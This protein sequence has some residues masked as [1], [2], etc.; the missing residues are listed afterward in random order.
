MSTATAWPT[1]VEGTGPPT[2]KP[3]PPGFVIRLAPDVRV[4]PRP[5]GGVLLGGSPLRVLR[6]NAAAWREFSALS[7]G[8]A[9]RSRAAGRVAARLVDAGIAEPVPPAA[10]GPG[11]EEVTIVIP[12]R[13]RPQALARCLATVGPAA[14]V[15]V[16]DDDSVRPDLVL[17]AAEIAGARVVRRASNGGPA[18]ARNTGLAACRT[19][20]VAFVDSDCSPEP[21]WLAGLLAHFAD[22]AVGAAAPRIVGL[23]SDSWLSRY[24]EQRSALD[25]GEHPGRVAPLTRIGYVPAAAIVIRRSALGAGFEERLR[26][27]EDVDLVWRLHAQGWRVRYEPA[28]RVRHE[29]PVSVGAWARRRYQYGTSGG[30]LGRRHP[31]KVRPAVTSVVAAAPLA[32]AGRGRRWPASP[33]RWCRRPGSDVGCHRSPGAGQRQCT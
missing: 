23:P 14:A 32:L 3:L 29:H 5:D 6:L 15:L 9:V 7:Q 4:R 1:R 19:P 16:V 25:M 20:L 18:A 26:V 27:G 12:V 8:L 30:Q 22:P 11:V 24:D 31:G 21:G 17:S 10:A 33:P 13:D 2:E 28:A